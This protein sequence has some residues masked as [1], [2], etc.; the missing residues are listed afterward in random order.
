MIIY[1]ILLAVDEDS[2]GY[3][4]YVFENLDNRYEYIM[5]T[6]YPNWEVRQ[7]EIGDK[8]FLNYKEIIAG[9]D[10]WYD[11]Q[12]GQFNHY[13]HSGFQ[14]VNFVVFD[15]TKSNICIM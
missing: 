5:C 14:F 13:N 15:R 6:R 7:M 1:C 2:S 8:G 9:R 10:M 12:S 11:K 3:T 4:T